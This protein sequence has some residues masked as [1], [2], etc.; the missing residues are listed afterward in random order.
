MSHIN[1]DSLINRKLLMFCFICLLNM[2]VLNLG[3][4]STAILIRLTNPLDDK[5]MIV[6]PQFN[7]RN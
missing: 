6:A 1:V 7:Q 2:E 3:S 4:V 5:Y